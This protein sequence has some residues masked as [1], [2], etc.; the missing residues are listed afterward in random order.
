[1]E[2]WLITGQ[3]LPGAP[4]GHC[5]PHGPRCGKGGRREGGVLFATFISEE[6]EVQRG[7]GVF[8]GLQRLSVRA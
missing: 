3:A 5:L 4:N 1:M 7:E 2:I 8:L 6:P